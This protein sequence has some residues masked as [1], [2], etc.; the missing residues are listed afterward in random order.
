MAVCVYARRRGKRTQAVGRS[1]G[2]QPASV[3]S[4]SHAGAPDNPEFPG[5]PENPVVPQGGIE[6]PQ[7]LDVRSSIALRVLAVLVAL[8][9]IGLTGIHLI[10]PRLPVSDWTLAVA[11]LWIIPEH[12]RP[13]VEWLLQNETW[14]GKRL[15]TLIEHA[16]LAGYNRQLVNWQI[17]DTMYREYVLS[18]EID[19]AADGQM[20]WR[21]RLWESFYPRVRREHDE[22]SAAEIVVRHLRER[23]T[24]ASN[25][26]GPV[27]IAE[28]WQRQ[29]A[30]ERKFEALYV[31]AMRSVCIP[32]RLN[33]D[34]RAEFHRQSQ[35][36]LAP[37]AVL[38]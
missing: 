31:A 32:A 18:P 8:V 1:A 24:I 12:E 15:R 29:M 34:G 2:L 9:A 33:D 3:Q 35:W 13:D 7:S 27:E 5:T 4:R 37:R 20:D 21:R 16:H 10:T 30:N 28:S 36:K 22:E 14:R 19:A 23:V 11:R 6:Q 38:E 26:A 17:D 25:A